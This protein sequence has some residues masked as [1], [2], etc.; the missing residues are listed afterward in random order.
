MG[1]GEEEP[2]IYDKNITV[3]TAR[4]TGGWGGARL[5]N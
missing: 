2:E 3:H 1:T 5:P 4:T